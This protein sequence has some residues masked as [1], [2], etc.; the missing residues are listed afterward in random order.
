MSKLAYIYILQDGNDKGTNIYK[1]GR[2]IQQNDT[3]K[4]DRLCSYTQG[5]VQY[6][7]FNV[8]ETEIVDIE[9]EIKKRFT[10]KYKLVR[11]TEWF[12]GDVDDMKKDIYKLLLDTAEIPKTN[13]Q[14]KNINIVPVRNFTV[15]DTTHVSGEYIVDCITRN[16][17]NGILDVADCIYFNSDHPENWNMKMNDRYSTSVYV[18]IDDTWRKKNIDRLGKEVMKTVVLFILWK[19]IAGGIYQKCTEF[20][21]KSEYWIKQGDIM[22]AHLRKRLIERLD[23]ESK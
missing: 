6:G 2:T 19:G 1:I 7:C 3:R 5:T 20:C 22:A 4:L 18:Y 16:G 10:E 12:Q 11:G 17:R 21:E 14:T 9:T 13:K 15:E 23:E 8:L